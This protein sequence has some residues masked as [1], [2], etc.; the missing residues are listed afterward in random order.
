MV[1]FMRQKLKS[2]HERYKKTAGKK[3]YAGFHKGGET[4]QELERATYL[5]RL[6]KRLALPADVFSS[7]CIMTVTGRY[8]LQ[9]ENYKS[10]VEYTDSRIRVQTKQ[11][12]VVVSGTQLRIAFF[13][14]EE[15]QIEGRIGRI[16]YQ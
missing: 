9:L 4:R 10:I 13:T 1:I 11:C 12:V 3:N 6:S 15:M 2:N 16:E 5:E 7:A 8:C 14:D